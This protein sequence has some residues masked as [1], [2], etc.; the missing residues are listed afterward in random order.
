MVFPITRTAKGVGDMSASRMPGRSVRRR[1][2]RL[3][4]WLFSPFGNHLFVERQ[5]A[6]S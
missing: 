1:A 6:G 5:V 3:L 2:A 4:G